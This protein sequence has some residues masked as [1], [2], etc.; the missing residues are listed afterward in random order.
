MSTRTPY[1]TAAALSD[2]GIPEWQIYF[3]FF[4]GLSPFVIASYEFG[5][6]PAGGLTRR[7]SFTRLAKTRIESLESFT[8]LVKQHVLIQSVK[9]SIHDA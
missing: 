2:T 6:A 3:G 8:R 1:T 4:A 5:G 9:R 7:E